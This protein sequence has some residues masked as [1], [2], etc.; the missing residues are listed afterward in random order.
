MFRET[1][2]AAPTVTLTGQFDDGGATIV[3]GGI[4]IERCT[5]NQSTSD[6]AGD[7]PSVYYWSAAAEL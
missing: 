3:A 1:M 7:A 2:R 5:F 4:G 6:A